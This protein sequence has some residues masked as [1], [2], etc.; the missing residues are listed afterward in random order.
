MAPKAI[1]LSENWR[2]RDF[3]LVWLAADGPRGLWQMRAL[4]RRVDKDDWIT[5]RADCVSG[6][7][8]V[9]PGPFARGHKFASVINWSQCRRMPLP[10]VT[11][12]DCH[13]D[14]DDPHGRFGAEELDKLIRAAHPPRGSRLAELGIVDAYR[15]ASRTPQ[16]AVSGSAFRKATAGTSSSGSA[17]M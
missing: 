6:T 2:P 4:I 9:A 11:R 5:M 17:I 15:K 10:E 16:R 3:L 7:E 1:V 14:E 8:N 13:L 12:A